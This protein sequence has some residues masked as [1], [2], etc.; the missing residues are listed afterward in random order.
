MNLRPSGLL[1]PTKA[2][3]DFLYFKIA[4]G[5]SESTITSYRYQL[6]LWLKQTGDMKLDEVTSGDLSRYLAWLRTEY[7]PKRL[8]G[9]T[10]ELSGKPLRLEMNKC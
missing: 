7:K 4:E 1:T 5:L 6:R 8:N 9:D 3:E 2:V 10:S